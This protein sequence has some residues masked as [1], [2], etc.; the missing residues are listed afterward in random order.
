MGGVFD[1]GKSR[2]E[3]IPHMHALADTLSANHPALES[4][5][6][7]SRRWMQARRVLS[8]RLAK[9]RLP[10]FFT[11]WMPTEPFS[12]V[13]DE[14]LSLEETENGLRWT[15][16]GLTADARERALLHLPALRA[17]WALELRST[18]FDALRRLVPRTWFLSPEAIP[19]GAVISGLG[20]AHW[21]DFARKHDSSQFLLIDETGASQPVQ[22]EKLDE[23][24]LQQ[25]FVLTEAPSASRM[26]A[27]RYQEDEK[28]HIRLVECQG[29][30]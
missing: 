21:R 3:T 16:G 13:E 19:H 11:T 1:I 9:N 6:Y 8:A 29:M 17:F 5:G 27:A 28:G 20:I 30:P 7:Q 26:L 4:V 15:G 23:L 14:T 18:H 25:R 12:A 10:P 24:A 2:A 22:P